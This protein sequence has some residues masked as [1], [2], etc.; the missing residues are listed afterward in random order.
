M[1]GAAINDAVDL[2]PDINDST[3]HV[4]DGSAAWGD[5]RDA[6]VKF[7]RCGGKMPRSTELSC[8]KGLPVDVVAWGC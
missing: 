1:D 6:A 7:C 2:G 4:G 8:H 5:A 3:R